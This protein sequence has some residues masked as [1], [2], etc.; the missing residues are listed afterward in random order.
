MG[1][2]KQGAVIS[3]ST[4]VG[5][6]WKEKIREESLSMGWLMK[7]EKLKLR[8]KVELNKQPT[9]LNFRNAMQQLLKQYPN[10]LTWDEIVKKAG[11]PQKKP[12]S[13]LIR[14]LEKDVGLKRFQSGGSVFWK[15]EHDGFY[16]IGYE[17]NDIDAFI[18]ILTDNQVEQ[19]IDVRELAFSRKSGFSK[20]L[21]TS[22]L[23]ER[24]IRY[25]HFPSLGSPRAIR[26]K[27]YESMDY[28]TFFKE[29]KQHI[30]DPD[31]FEELK[32][33]ERMGKMRKVVLM[34]YE[35]DYKRCHRSIIAEILSNRGWKIINLKS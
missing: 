13:G 5:L 25:N 14:R 8:L 9:Y 34:C 11:L 35:E 22:F 23:K 1:C 31:V 19:L 26:K 21:L 18:E 10:G 24:G 16:T 17:G 4:T 12:H 32:D 7:D 28:E 6:G 29:Y 27:L 33:V 15:I 30:G 3:D 2:Q 20:K